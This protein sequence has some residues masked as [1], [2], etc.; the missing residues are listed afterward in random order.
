MSRF[1]LILLGVVI[2]MLVATQFPLWPT[3]AAGLFRD[4]NGAFRAHADG[5][6]HPDTTLLYCPGEISDGFVLNGAS[7]I[8]SMGPE[9]VYRK[10]DSTVWVYIDLQVGKADAWPDA[11]P[12]TVQL[13]DQ[14]YPAH[15]V[16]NLGKASSSP[17]EHDMVI[18]TGSEMSLSISC[19]DGP[20]PPLD[21]PACH[22]LQDAYLAKIH[23][24]NLGG[25]GDGS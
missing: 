23:P 20:T 18:V 11:T 4:W 6:L 12:V 9:C 14:P 1:L 13:L 5:A 7:S 2:G 21:V 22:A 16:I 3:R 15:R 17:V 24:M 25:L 19:S 8:G 10:P